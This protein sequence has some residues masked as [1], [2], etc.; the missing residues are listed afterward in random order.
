MK[1]LYIFA[2]VTLL[3]VLLGGVWWYYQHPESISACDVL[4]GKTGEEIESGVVLQSNGELVISIDTDENARFVMACFDERLMEQFLWLVGLNVLGLILLGTFLYTN[5]EQA[6]RRQLS[7][8]AKEVILSI[9]ELMPV[10]VSVENGRVVIT[11][12]LNGNHKDSD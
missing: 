5:I 10:A 7:N 4:A 12:R 1:S 11:K 8:S 3:L 2:C 9:Q 6:L